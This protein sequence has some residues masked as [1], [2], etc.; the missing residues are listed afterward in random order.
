MDEKRKKQMITL[1]VDADLMNLSEI[2]DLVAKRI[3]S[4]FVEKLISQYFESKY[5]RMPTKEDVI[6]QMDAINK[7]MDEGRE[8]LSGLSV[9]LAKFKED[10]D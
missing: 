2:K 6:S 1:Y 10:N 7:A 8:R 9:M 3:F 4:Q 5:N